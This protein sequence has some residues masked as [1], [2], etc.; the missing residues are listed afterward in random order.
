[1]SGSKIK[2]SSAYHFSAPNQW[3]SM[4]SDLLIEEMKHIPATNTSLPFTQRDILSGLAWRVVLT[5]HYKLSLDDV[6]YP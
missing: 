6:C 4:S 3:E 1:M 2:S 5:R